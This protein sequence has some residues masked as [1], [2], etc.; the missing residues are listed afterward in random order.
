[1]F[2]RFDVGVRT[3]KDASR[4]K[5][6]AHRFIDFPHFRTGLRDDHSRLSARRDAKISVRQP[7]A[8]LAETALDHRAQF[9]QAPHRRDQLPFSG[10]FHGPTIFSHVLPLQRARGPRRILPPNLVEFGGLQTGIALDRAQRVG[11]FHWP[12][13]PRVAGKDDAALRFL[14]EAQEVEHLTPADLPGFID[15]QDRAFRQRTALQKLGHGLGVFQPVA[16]E[17]GDLLALRRSDPCG[18]TFAAERILNAPKHEGLAC[19]RASTEERD[20]VRR[21]KYLPEREKLV[22]GKFTSFCSNPGGQRGVTAR[23]IAGCFH[24]GP[25]AGEHITSGNLVA[26]GAQVSAGMRFVF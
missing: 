23:S 15:D 3:G 19:A 11:C 22:G 4:A 24:N 25:F 10:S 2:E 14:H 6:S 17:V 21:T 13:L 7:L 18:A 9:L 5:P 1:M 26:F 20:E 12:M 16:P 8:L